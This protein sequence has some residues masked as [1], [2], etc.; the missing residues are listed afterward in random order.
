MMVTNNR[1]IAEIKG[2]IKPGEI[3]A[4]GEKRDAR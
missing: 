3:V 4:L 1:R 2:C